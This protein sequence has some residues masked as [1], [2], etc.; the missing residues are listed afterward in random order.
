LAA[1]Y[2]PDVN[3]KSPVET[4]SFGNIYYNTFGSLKP[5]E[6]DIF[7]QEVANIFA[8]GWTSGEMLDEFKVKV[9]YHTYK[10]SIPFYLAGEFLYQYL[11]KT[12]RKYYS[13]NHAKDYFSTYF[14]FDIF[15]NS[16]L[17]QILKNSQ[18][19]GYLRIK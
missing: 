16:Y 6:F 1:F 2:A 10:K 11:D 13:Q 8:S 7:P 12:S 17:N 3:K 5:C 9:A 4:D 19:K 14:I 15:N 18:E